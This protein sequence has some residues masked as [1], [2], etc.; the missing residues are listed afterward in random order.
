MFNNQTA[1]KVI[2]NFLT[3]TDPTVKVPEIRPELECLCFSP[4]SSLGD[5]DLSVLC[6]P[7]SSTTKIKK[8][9]TAAYLDKLS[10]SLVHLH[11]NVLPGFA[12]ACEWQM[13]VLQQGGDVGELAG[14]PGDLRQAV[15][16]QPG[17]QL[18]DRFALKWK[19]AAIGLQTR[20]SAVD[21]V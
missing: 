4:R 2:S 19:A 21:N 16:Q 5:V 10:E 12:H 8:K 17:V 7:C 13:Q 11:K 18:G 20:K 3:L 14:H 9:N 15:W 1:T 6:C